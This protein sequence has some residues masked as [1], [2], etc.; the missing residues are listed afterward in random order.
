[1]LPVIFSLAGLLLLA[2]CVSSRDPQWQA[3]ITAAKQAAKEKR[4]AEAEAHWKQALVEAERSG[5]DNWRVASTL[6]PMARL[7]ESQGRTDEAEQAF[8]RTLAI[9]ERI[10]PRSPAAA[11]TLTDLAHRGSSSGHTR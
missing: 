10:A 9:H 2:G 3:S 11:R 7:Y 1:M 4:S 8:K 6:Q 5:P